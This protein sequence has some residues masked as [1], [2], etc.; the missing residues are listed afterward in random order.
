M[1]LGYRMTGAKNARHAQVITNNTCIFGI[2]GGLAGRMASL[3][4]ITANDA[5]NSLVNSTPPSGLS[6][7]GQRNWM[8]IKGLLSRN[9]A[10]SGGVGLQYPTAHIACCPPSAGGASNLQYSVAN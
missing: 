3:P 1:A 2:M 9:P 4:G 8:G 5:T 6:C 7:A 10:G